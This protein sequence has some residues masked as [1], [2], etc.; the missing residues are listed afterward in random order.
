MEESKPITSPVP[1]QAKPT[2]RAMGLPEAMLLLR[3]GKKITK[4]EWNNGDYCLLKDGWLQICRSGV[5]HTW[6]I[7][8]GDLMGEDWGEYE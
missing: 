8:D 2:P 5:F 6:L 1:H 3:E 4:A 7:N